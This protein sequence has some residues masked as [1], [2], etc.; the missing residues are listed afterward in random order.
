M[1]VFNPSLPPISSSTTSVRPGYAEPTDSSKFLAPSTA[2]RGTI[3]ET[4]TNPALRTRKS[5]LEMDMVVLRVVGYPRWNAGLVSI[6]W[7]RPRTFFSMLAVVFVQF[8]RLQ[9]SFA[10]MYETHAARTS[11]ATSAMFRRSARIS[12]TLSAV[13]ASLPAS[14]LFGS[15]RVPLV[16]RLVASELA[17]EAREKTVPVFIQEVPQP[18]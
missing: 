4:V 1:T 18:H 2:H 15:K 11:G 7:T 14:N 12:T 9:S 16:P 10:F 17:S 8:P 6:R 3:A 5:R 13:E